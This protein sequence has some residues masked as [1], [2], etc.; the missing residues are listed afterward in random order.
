MRVL[1]S[2]STGLVGSALCARLVGAGH[3][4][5]RLRRGS[6]CADGQNVY[7]DPESG[8]L[9]PNS[10]LGCDAVVHLAGESIAAGRWTAERKR[11]IRQSR[12]DSTRLLSTVLAEL[13]NRAGSGTAASPTGTATNDAQS[14]VVPRVLLSASAVGIYGDRSEAV[15]DEDSPA[16][17]GFLAE[18]CQQWE[19]ATLPATEAGLRVVCLRFGVVLA[20]HGG[21]LPR[22]LA[23]FR[24]GLGGRL[25]HGRQYMSWVTLAD[26]V[27]AIVF[28]L[29][30]Q[31][32]RGPVNIVAP[33]PVTNRQFTA[34]LAAALRRP[35][36]VPIPAIA[37][38]LLLGQMADELLLSS[39][40]VIP[41]RLT[42][43]GYRFADPELLP[44]LRRVL[45][46]SAP[47]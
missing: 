36:I 10:L 21:A 2:G 25:G 38:R 40:R 23:P 24:W 44:A 16:G 9:D 22:M 41:R 31:S 30:H 27:G 17:D 12:V 8:R 20:R 29:G 33:E 5:V 18:L 6:G 26:A 15:L 43:S 28:L 32:I 7:W 4:V 47:A 34:A 35:A 42:D 11:R 39:A 13:A 37:L 45:A 1:V 46:E 19:A 3:S 14:V